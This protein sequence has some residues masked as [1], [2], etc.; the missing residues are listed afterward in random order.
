[1]KI[2]K[3]QTLSFFLKFLNPHESYVQRYGSQIKQSHELPSFVSEIKAPEGLQLAADFKFNGVYELEGDIQ[4]LKLVDLDRENLSEYRSQVLQRTGS[5]IAVSRLSHGTHLNE[6]SQNSSTSRISNF[7]DTVMRSPTFFLPTTGASPYI[8]P[9]GNI[10]IRNLASPSTQT[11]ENIF[12]AITRTVENKI[13]RE[14][15]ERA[16]LVLNSRLGRSYGEDDVDA[17]FSKLDI[18]QDGYTD[19]EEFKRVYL[20]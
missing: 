16:L 2:P 14:D 20:F 9:L 18:N 15:A 13:T 11:I 17:F 5:L 6:S 19:F 10:G 3:A 12:N 7:D 4:A 8:C 1:M